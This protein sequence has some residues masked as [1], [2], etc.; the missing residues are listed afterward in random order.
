M[1]A[2]VLDSPWECQTNGDTFLFLVLYL[3]FEVIPTL[4]VIP[5]IQLHNLRP[6]EILEE[7]T[8]KGSKVLQAS[9]LKGLSTFSAGQARSPQKSPLPRCEPLL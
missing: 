2:P 3:L 1:P 4:L 8:G 9:W 5:I 7:R 6:R